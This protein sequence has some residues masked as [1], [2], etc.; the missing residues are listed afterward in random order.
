MAKRIAWNKGKTKAT[1]E[2]LKKAGETFSN[3]LKEGKT[4]HSQTG[5]PHSEKYK[6]KLSDIVN[7]KVNEGTWHYSFSKSRTVEYNGIKMLGSWEIKFAKW[8][9]EKQIKWERVKN[10]FKY[11]FNDKI[12]QY[13]PDF[14]LP[15]FD[16]YIE[17]KGYPVPKDFAKWE[18]FP[19]TLA[20]LSG[21]LLQQIGLDIQIKKLDVTYKN[22]S[23]K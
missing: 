1:D 15:E 7:T 10:T 9:D 19:K 4:I 8:L 14:Y 12:K 3:N 2:R 22:V 6:K 17:I 11:Q 13:T 5:K 21:P 16:T 18:Q 23:W 20:I